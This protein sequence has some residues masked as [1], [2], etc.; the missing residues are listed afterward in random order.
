MESSDRLYPENRSH[1]IL[2]AVHFLH[3][4]RGSLLR[5]KVEIEGW[6]DKS[7]QNEK[8]FARCL[9]RDPYYLATFEA[10]ALE[11]K[12]MPPKKPLPLLATTERELPTETSRNTPT[13]QQNTP[14]DKA[15]PQVRKLI[16]GQHLGQRNP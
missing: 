12:T 4:T 2:G 9:F 7:K 10:I 15:H 14:P 11:E 1:T 3:S 5:V 13:C 16:H 6:F 8:H